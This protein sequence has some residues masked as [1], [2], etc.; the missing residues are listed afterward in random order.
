M[1]LSVAL[2]I[3]GL[4]PPA[5]LSAPAP[6]AADDEPAR[7][8]VQLGAA[9]G[10]RT[11]TFGA[12]WAWRWQQPLWRGRATGYW[13]VSAGRWSSEV[14]GAPPA[15]AWITQLGLT[16]VLR[17]YLPSGTPA[18]F[19]EAGVGAN[20]LL[21]VYRSREK[22][23]STAFNFGDHLALGTRFG[24]AGAHELALRVQ[25]Y[26]NAGIRHPNPGEN[27]VQLRGSFAF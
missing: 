20:A 9:E 4:L 17:W 3:A 24:P 22:R 18:W 8:F 11:M 12:T 10:V 15:S 7:W 6:T 13:E 26:S 25:H 14:S 16:P 1:R 2:L 27:F 5:A 23:F 19:V 21:P